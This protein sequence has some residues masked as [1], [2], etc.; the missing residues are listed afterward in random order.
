V[1]FAVMGA[2]GIG[3]PLG[4]SP[5]IWYFVAVFFATWAINGATSKWIIQR[6][7]NLT[8]KLDV[9]LLYWFIARHS[10]L[11]LF[12]AAAVVG[13]VALALDV[14]GVPYGRWIDSALEG[15]VG[16]REKMPELDAARWSLCRTVAELGEACAEYLQGRLGSQPA[17]SPRTPV[18][19][20]T[21]Q[22]IPVL[23][24]LNLAGF[25]TTG[26]QPGNAED[27]GGIRM[28][29]WVTGFADAKTMRSLAT[30][31]A[32]ERGTGY[33][34]EYRIRQTRMN[35]DH[36][37]RGRIRWGVDSARKVR[38]FY[39]EVCSEDAVEQLLLAY[40]IVIADRQIGRDDRIWPVLEAWADAR[41]R[42][43]SR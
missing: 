6:S 33:G 36:A 38:A 41:I 12:T 15:L 11:W 5:H 16:V 20:E 19:D 4:R 13:T 14:L 10:D 25:Y 28:H 35:R 9:V 7:A 27:A 30:L 18:D 17:Y 31:L 32:D 22:L 42:A 21:D 43:A 8:M 40:Q 1:I 24:K 39:G 37:G 26:S 34:L 29:A 2:S 23:V 3:T